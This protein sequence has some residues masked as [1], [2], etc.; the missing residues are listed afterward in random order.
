MLLTYHATTQ[1]KTKLKISI[2]G[3]FEDLISNKVDDAVALIVAGKG[4]YINWQEE[5]YFQIVKKRSKEI[6]ASGWMME[7]E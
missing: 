3:S 1:K 5:D 4:H 6:V 2:K 7:K